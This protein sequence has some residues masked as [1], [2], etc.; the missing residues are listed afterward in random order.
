MLLQNISQI[1][2]EDRHNSYWTRYIYS[3]WKRNYL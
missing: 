1:K 2:Y 3:Q